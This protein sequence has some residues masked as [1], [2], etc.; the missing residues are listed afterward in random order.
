MKKLLCLALAAMLCL[1]LA[2]C[3]V[4]EGTWKIAILT[5]TTSQG[6]EEFRAAER[7]QKADPEHIITDTYPD[8]FMAETETTISK[9]VAFASDPD[10]KAIV[11]CQAVPGAKAAFDKIRAMGRDDMLLIAGVPQE[12]PAVITAAADFVLYTDEP[13]QGDTIMETCAKW[14]VDVFVHYSFPRHLAYETMSRRV[15]VMKAAC[16]EFGMSFEMETAPDPTSDVGVAG[17]QA[18]IL[19]KV[20]EWVNK[21]GEKAAYFC[22]N[23]AHTEPLLKQLLE[24]GGYFIEADLPS[25]LMG[26]PGAL[27]I[28]L[29]AEAGDF[30]KILAKVEAAICEKG[31]AGRFGT[32]AYSYGYVTSAGLAQHAMNVIKGESELADIDDIAK[33]YHQFSPDA[34]WNGSNYTNATTGVKADNTFLVYQDTYIMGDPGWFMHATEVEV[35]EKYFTVK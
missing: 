10:V 24:Y 15:A 32:W 21:Y 6:E 4:A 27:G 25:P 22:T 29:T 11:M 17:A 23:D 20:P 28:D 9:L 5:G 1:A 8:N 34:S 19:E 18:Y 30:Q 2:A 7:A 35:P 33:A 3:A 16:E 31:G 26:Y 13:K 12:D 14:G